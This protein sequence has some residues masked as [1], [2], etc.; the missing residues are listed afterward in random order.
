[1]LILNIGEFDARSHKAA[2][3]AR[4]AEKPLLLI[5]IDQ[6]L[7]ATNSGIA[8]WLVANRISVVYVAGPREGVRPGATMAARRFFATLAATQRTAA[9]S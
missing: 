5:Q 2:E 8:A 9:P 1:M 4:R 6:A 7:D 3:A